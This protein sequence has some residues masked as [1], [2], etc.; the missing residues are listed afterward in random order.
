MV[1][2]KKGSKEGVKRGRGSKGGHTQGSKAKG[3]TPDTPFL[4]GELFFGLSNGLI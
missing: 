1:K 3:D 4:T 2:K